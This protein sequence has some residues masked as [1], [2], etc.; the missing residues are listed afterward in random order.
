VRQQQE[1]V[2]EAQ[3]FEALEKIHRDKAS[4]AAPRWAC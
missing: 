1:L 2:S 4:G 3:V